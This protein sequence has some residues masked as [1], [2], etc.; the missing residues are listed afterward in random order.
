MDIKNLMQKMHDATTNKGKLSIKNE[1]LSQFNSLSE[2]EKEIVRN[3][4]MEGLDAKL[5][6]AEVLIKEIDIAIEISKLSNEI[7][8]KI[9]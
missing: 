5:R 1:I 2:S 4:F 3:E 7:S 9:A 6:E 8:L